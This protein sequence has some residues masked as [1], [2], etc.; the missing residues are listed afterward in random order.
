MLQMNSDNIYYI[1]GGELSPG[2]PMH[3]K[4]NEKIINAA[5]AFT[6]IE[7]GKYYIE[8][9]NIG[10]EYKISPTTTMSNE[11]F[12]KIKLLL[13]DTKDEIDRA[14]KNQNEY[15]FSKHLS[16]WPNELIAT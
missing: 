6:S 3:I 13:F 1:S 12:G 8:K 4:V 16:P 11:Y 9:L 7:V 14:Y 2:M 5:L 15:D 10:S